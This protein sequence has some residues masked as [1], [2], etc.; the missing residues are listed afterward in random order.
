VTR[1]TESQWSLIYAETTLAICEFLESD[2]A[3]SWKVGRVDYKH[4]GAFVYTTTLEQIVKYTYQAAAL[5]PRWGTPIVGGRKYLVAEYAESGFHVKALNGKLNHDYSRDFGLMQIN[6]RHLLGYPSLF[7]YFRHYA[8]LPFTPKSIWDIK[9]N[10]FFGAYLNERQIESGNV[11]YPVD[12]V[13]IAGKTYTYRNRDDVMRLKKI[14]FV[15]LPRRL[16][17]VGIEVPVAP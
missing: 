5:S 14:L 9:T 4:G 6:E 16:R 12:D 8:H 7:D 15:D 11:P 17:A 13:V 2:A 1:Y 3:G 10:I